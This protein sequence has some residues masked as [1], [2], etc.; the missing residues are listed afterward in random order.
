MPPKGLPKLCTCQAVAFKRGCQLGKKLARGLASHGPTGRRSV[1]VLVLSG[2]QVAERHSDPTRTTI[3]I[4]VRIPSDMTARQVPRTNKTDHQNS[5]N[6]GRPGTLNNRRADK[7][8]LVH[9]DRIQGVCGLPGIHQID[10]PE[11][12]TT[13]AP[14]CRNRRQPLPDTPSIGKQSDNHKKF[15]R[16]N[17]RTG[18]VRRKCYPNPTNQ[19]RGGLKGRAK[20]PLSRGGVPCKS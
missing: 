15:L 9:L 10:W 12:I 18:F 20:L 3:P 6:N 1:H 4:R 16:T 13:D 14:T 5:A 11:P 2:D 7:P 19:P 8:P 17:G